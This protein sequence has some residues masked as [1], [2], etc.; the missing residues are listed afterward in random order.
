MVQKKLNGYGTV[1]SF[2]FISITILKLVIDVKDKRI[3]N[4]MDKILL[5]FK[6]QKKIFLV[7]FH[8]RGLLKILN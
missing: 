3:S 4:V 2:N 1:P 6:Y 8:P 5:K 7:I